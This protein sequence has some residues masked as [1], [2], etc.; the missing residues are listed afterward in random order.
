MAEP[1]KGILSRMLRSIVTLHGSPK[2]I[3]L[4]TA[5]GVFIAFTPTVG[6][7]M[8][9]GAFVA[10][11]V[12]ASRPAAMIPALITNP[13]TI[14]PIYAFTYWLGKFFWSGP[15]V[16]EV[17]HRLM[18]AMKNLTK[19]TWYSFHDQFL[20]FLRIGVDVFVPMMIGGVIVGA[21]CAAVAYPVVLRSVTKSRDLL[22]KAKEKLAARGSRKR[23]GQSSKANDT[24]A[25]AVARITAEGIA[26]DSAREQSPADSP[27]RQAAEHTPRGR[28]RGG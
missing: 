22:G 4:G 23:Q 25:E 5:I 2:A 20:E 28:N 24:K 17:Y 3:A 13:V 18:A 21:I 10:T 15:A 7:Q 8:L 1:P 19:L 9:L 26:S 6:F 14:P 16:G 12:S 27:G 11:L